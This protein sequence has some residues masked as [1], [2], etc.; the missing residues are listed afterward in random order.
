MLLDCINE[1][2]IEPFSITNNP[3][4]KIDSLA[5]LGFLRHS[6]I[7]VRNLLDLNRRPAGEPVRPDEFLCNTGLPCGSRS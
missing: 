3:S 7:Q 5:T 4:S 2:C 6:Y 1:L